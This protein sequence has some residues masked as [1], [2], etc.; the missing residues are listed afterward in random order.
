MSMLAPSPGVPRPRSRGSTGLWGGDWNKFA[1]TTGHWNRAIQGQLDRGQ[2]ATEDYLDRARAFDARAGLNEWASGAF[3][4]LSGDLNRTLGDMAGQATGAGRLNTGFFDE[5]RGQVIQ[6]VMRDF[7]QAL[8]QQAMAAQ[9]MQ[10]QNDQALGAYGQRMTETG[11]EGLQARREEQINNERERAARRRAR[12]AAIGGLLGQ[13]A[14]SF[15]PGVGPTVG[16][17]IGGAIGSW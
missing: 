2:Q 9:G 13:V 4:M 15:L 17:M 14:G 6:N 5:D 11:M 3:S 7:S 10:L 8:A 12:G 16:G 1:T